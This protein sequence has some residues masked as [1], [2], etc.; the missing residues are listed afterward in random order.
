MIFGMLLPFFIIF[1]L[2]TKLFVLAFL[3][4]PFLVLLTVTFMVVAYTETSKR[5]ELE[6]KELMNQIKG[7]YDKNVKNK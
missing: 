1:A 2:S 6:N 7:N 5:I 4:I 3:L